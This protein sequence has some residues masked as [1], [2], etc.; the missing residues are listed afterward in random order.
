[1][2]RGERVVPGVWRLRLP[3]PWPGVPHCNAWALA[4]GDGIVLVD[5]GMD[6]PGS[7]RHLE[8]ALEQVGLRLE[9]VRLLV[10]T[11]AH[12]DHCGQAAAVQARTGCELWIHPRH[13]HLTALSDDPEAALARRIEVARQSGVPEAPLREWAEGRR[14]EGSGMSGPLVPARDLLPG[15]VVETDLG[16]WSVIETPGHAPSHVVL[17]Q[18]ERRLLISGDHVLGRI[19]LYFDHGWTPDPVGEFLASLDRVAGLDVRL[20]LSGHGRPFTDLNGHVEGNRAL[21]RERLDAV[22][23]VL[24]ERGDATAFDLLPAVYG[25]KLVPATAAWLLTKTLCYLEH[26]EA[27]GSVRRLDTDPQRW[28]AA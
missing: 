22:V 8:R 10:C 23:A 4:A 26:L 2:G 24:R 17:H 20:T 12:I 3:L 19:S 25:E 18:P 1:M 14:G 27:G 9:L 21:V 13:E 11:H 16:P 6:E 5:C 15:V 7:M 28:G